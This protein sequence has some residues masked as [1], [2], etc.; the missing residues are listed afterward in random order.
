MEHLAVAADAGRPG[1]TPALA[2]SGWFQPV[3]AGLGWD[4]AVG[5]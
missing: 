5:L 1:L 4:R 3:H 2:G